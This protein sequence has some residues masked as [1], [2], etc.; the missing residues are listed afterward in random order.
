MEEMVCGQRQAVDWSASFGLA[1]VERIAM[2]SS[3]PSQMI[4]S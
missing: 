3:K 4:N 2:P 1:E